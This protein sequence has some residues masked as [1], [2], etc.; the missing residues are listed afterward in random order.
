MREYT[1]KENGKAFKGIYTN[2]YMPNQKPKRVRK[3]AY[4]QVGEDVTREMMKVNINGIGIGAA[5]M[6]FFYVP[7]DTGWKIALAALF[8]LSAIHVEVEDNE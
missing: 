7:L 6:T 8:V 1:G 5:L 4:Q 2:S 3:S